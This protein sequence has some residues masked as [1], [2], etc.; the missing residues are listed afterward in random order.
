[1]GVRWSQTSMSMKRITVLLA[2]DRVIDRAGLS[3]DAAASHC[4]T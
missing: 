4:L 1:M 3:G 2:E